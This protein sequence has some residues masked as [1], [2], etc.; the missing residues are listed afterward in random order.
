[1]PKAMRTIDRFLWF[2]EWLV[3]LRR[4]LYRRLYGIDIP[5]SASV[6]FSAR[7]RATAKG[8][9]TI[10][11]DTLIAFKTLVLGHDPATGREAPVVIGRRCFIG[12]NS[13]IMPGVTIGD[14]SIVG[15]G[16]FVDR[17]VPPDSIVVGSPFRVLKTGIHAGKKGRLPEADA[18]AAEAKA[19]V[20]TSTGH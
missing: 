14:G 15:A 9:I 20:A 17:D 5:R 11:E 4:P 12:G 8:P 1:M 7:F 6:S 3:N 19:R 2:R 18:R 16:S 13:L 10:G